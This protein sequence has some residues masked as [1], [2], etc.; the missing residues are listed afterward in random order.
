MK[1][2]VS[3]VVA[4]YNVEKYIA[5]CLDSLINQTLENIEIIVVNDCATDQTLQIVNQYAKNDHRI[6]VLDKKVN[7]GLS[8][9]RNSGIKSAKGEYI[10]FVDGDDF[11]E[12]N[13]YEK[14]YCEAK[15]NDVDQVVFKAL[16][17]KTDG[18]IEAIEMNSSKS[19]YSNKEDL[20]LYFAEMIGTLPIEKSDY[21]IGFAPWARM[22]KT[23]I[24]KDNNIKFISERE[25]IY[26]DLMFALNVTPYMKK[27]EIIDEAFYHYCENGESL[28]RKIDVNR[29]YRVKK[30]FEYIKNEEK[31]AS[32]FQ[33]SEY[34]IR[35]KRTIL[36]YIRLS[37][38][39]LVNAGTK[40]ENEIRKIANDSMCR[41]ILK[42]YP[43]LKL[44]FGQAIFAMLLKYKCILGLKIIVKLKYSLSN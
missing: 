30:M 26:E 7:E 6:V 11:L 20:E 17:D 31:Y 1:P 35:F 33:N 32:I 14:C 8:M 39:Q 28:T 4:A 15:K 27:V 42:N 18:S 38:I 16:L 9:A 13:T 22:Y 37:V 43:V 19:L 10:A 41:F 29:Y 24:L 44:P 21:Q 34:L 40:Y 25:L 23:K 36:S 3:I 2:C 12:E 5:R